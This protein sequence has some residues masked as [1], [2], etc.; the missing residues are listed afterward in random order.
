[1]GVLAAELCMGAEYMGFNNRQ[2]NINMS[3]PTTQVF[4]FV[5]TSPYGDV[6]LAKRE[7]PPLG[8]LP[9]GLLND[10]NAIYNGSNVEIPSFIK[11]IFD[12]NSSDPSAPNGRPV[13]FWRPLI[14]SWS[15]K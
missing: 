4:A 11:E 5:K 15:R 6:I 2:L 10:P 3:V 7:N 9:P 8:L 12:G 13:S 14:D 1:M